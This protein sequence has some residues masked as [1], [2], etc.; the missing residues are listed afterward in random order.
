MQAFLCHPTVKVNTSSHDRSPMALLD[1]HNRLVGVG[2]DMIIEIIPAKDESTDLKIYCQYVLV[3]LVL[4]PRYSSPK[5]QRS[6]TYTLSIKTLHR[7]D[8]K[9]IRGLSSYERSEVSLQ[10]L[11]LNFVHNQVNIFIPYDHISSCVL[12]QKLTATI[13]L[14]FGFCSSTCILTRRKSVIGIAT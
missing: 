11:E 9:R 3:R 10:G 14:T 12:F 1:R 4:V 7:S 6:S 5:D 2:Q 8:A 13:T